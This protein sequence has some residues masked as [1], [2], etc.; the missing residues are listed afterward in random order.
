MPDMLRLYDLG[1]GPLFAVSLAVFLLGMA[2]RVLRFLQ[3][4]KTVDPA[5]LKGFRPG[6]ALK[7]ILRWLVPAN[8]SAREN[9]LP[10]LAG[11]V[12]HIGVLGVALFL[13]AH[14]VLWDQAWNVSWITLPDEAADWLA[15]AALAAGVFLIVRRLAAPHV[16]AL[17]G[18]KD[19]LVLGLTLCP[20][21]TGICAYHQWGDYDT[22]IALHV[23]SADALLFLAPFTKLSHVVL[24]FVSR[25]VT[26]SDFG[27][28]QVGAW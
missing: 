26:G 10:T 21:L 4:A 25:A 3:L 8:I 27:K 18:P 20:M 14:V 6:W 11:F 28:R 22:F 1:A 16:R 9:P 24:F 7:S 5:A 2:G 17:T 15:L 19:W 12:L 23:L 13:Q